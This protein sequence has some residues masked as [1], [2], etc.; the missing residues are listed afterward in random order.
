MNFL[1]IGAGLVGCYFARDAM[2]KGHRV[3]L[4]DVAPNRAYIG[5]VAPD[6]AVVAGDVRDLPALIETMRANSI[7]VV[8]HSAFLIGAKAAARPYTTL[9]INVGGTTAVAEAV[10]IS[11]ARRLIF[12]GT[13]AVYLREPPPSVPIREDFAVGGDQLYTAS[14]V[15]CERILSALATHY[16]FE[17]AILRFAQI[18]GRGHYAGGDPAGEVLHAIL[19]S[20]LQGHPVSIDPGI[21][22]ARDCVYVKDVVQGVALAAEATLASRVFN[23]GS[24]LLTTADHIAAAIR[25]TVPGAEAAVVQAGSGAPA[26]AAGQPLD[27]SLAREEL[28]YQP[29]FTIDEGIAEFVRELREPDSQA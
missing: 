14:K 10:R 26:P 9:D 19:A 21:F 23:L 8:F 18:Y 11:G 12:A 13:Q 28:G 22:R 1:V 6:A 16:Q 20:A 27:I 15:A 2:S 17:L 4:Y 5:S 24:G 25:A 29:Q 7:E 3:V